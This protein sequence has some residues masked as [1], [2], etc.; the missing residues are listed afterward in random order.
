MIYIALVTLSLIFFCMFSLSISFNM[1]ISIIVGP[2][3]EIS[4]IAFFL[5]NS[6]ST[7]VSVDCEKEIL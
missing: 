6:C 4:E 7:V 2:I 3:L 1:D 5:F